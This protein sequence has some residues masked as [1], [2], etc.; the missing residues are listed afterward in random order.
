M[1]GEGEGTPT[2]VYC[3]DNAAEGEGGEFS[4]GSPIFA[5]PIEASTVDR[6]GSEIRARH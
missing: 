3:E 6:D 2:L 1:E 4:D 5:L